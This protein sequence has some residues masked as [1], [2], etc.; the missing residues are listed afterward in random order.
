MKNLK[1]I[2]SEMLDLAQKARRPKT[3]F[4]FFWYVLNQAHY[5]YNI[6]FFKISRGAI[7]APSLYYLFFRLPGW[8]R[9]RQWSCWGQRSCWGTRQRWLVLLG[10]WSIACMTSA[11][12]CHYNFFQELCNRCNS[13][14][15][16]D[17]AKERE[18]AII[19]KKLEEW[20][21]ESVLVQFFWET[22]EVKYK[23]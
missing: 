8:R 4:F 16:F 9:W 22:S 15:H 23:K 13:F 6:Y 17:L 1:G 3:F 18:E 12:T 5:I 20:E 11:P 19:W 10:T 14:W 2:W 7:V 21:R